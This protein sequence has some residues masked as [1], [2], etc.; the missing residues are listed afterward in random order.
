M[1]PPN[2]RRAI[3][4]FA[5]GSRDPL[6]RR[7]MEA[8]AARIAQQAPDTAVRC[9]YLEMIQ[10]DLESCVTTLVNEHVNCVTI[11]PMF[12][13]TGKHARDDLPRLVTQ[14]TKRFPKIEIGLQV[15]IGENPLMID[16]MAQIALMPSTT[17]ATSACP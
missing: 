17:Q 16:L 1:T 11:V 8:V 2:L 6:W 3:V 13:G 7:P 12:L 10:P 4:L 9:A 15:A 5:H 14:L